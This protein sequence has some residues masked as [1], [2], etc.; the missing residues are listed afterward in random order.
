VPLLS[1]Q[2][3]KTLCGFPPTTD[4][5]TL[6][7]PNGRWRPDTV[8]TDVDGNEIFV[9]IE[10]TN[11]MRSYEVVIGD[12]DGRRLVCV[13]RHLMKAF[14]RDGFYFCTYRPNYPGQKAL[15]DRDIDNKKVYPF[16]YLEVQ[17]LKGIFLYRHFD[18]YEQLKPPRLV[19]Q[20]P[21]LGFMTVCCTPLM[22]FGNFSTRFRKAKS[23]RT[24][25][26]IDQWS[27]TV[28]VGPGND[29]LAALCI[30]YVFDRVQGQPLI[31]VIG[32][33]EEEELEEEDVSIESDEED[34]NDNKR[35]SQVELQALP[36][37]SSM[38]SRNNAP[39]GYTD[40]PPPPNV[41]G[42]L[43]AGPS[44]A[45]G[46][47]QD[48]RHDEHEPIIDPYQSNAPDDGQPELL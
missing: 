22:R 43:E 13:K 42:Y 15:T 24:T 14:W 46:D 25:L 23:S 4:D 5:V 27:N 17:P 7:V 30:A 40:E 35:G 8:I 41:R 44:A 36:P 47:A 10:Q 2:P 20:N 38:K 16:S 34:G 21:W 18:A 48:D 19:S 1:L 45:N 6:L 26:A 3:W 39:N 12:L 33:D 37:S 9:V 29:L 31:T 32:R 28:K 11:Q